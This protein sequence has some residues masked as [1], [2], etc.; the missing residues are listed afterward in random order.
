MMI[1]DDEFREVYKTS[2]TERLQKLESGLIHL[3]KNP[4]DRAKLEELLREAHT[5]KGDSRMLGVNDVET[6]THQME[7][8]LVAVKRG[9]EAFTS[10][11]CDRL[12][13]GLDAICKLVHEAVTGEE[14]GV[15]VFSVLAQLMG[16]EAENT[17]QSSEPDLFDNNNWLQ[18]TS[19]S[20]LQDPSNLLSESSWLEELANKEGINAEELFPLLDRSI[21]FETIPDIDPIPNSLAIANPESTTSDRIA[22]TEVKSPSKQPS[23]ENSSENETIR[24]DAAKLDMLMRQ[25]GELSVTKLRVER[26]LTEIEEII[27]LWEE[28]SQDSSGSRMIFRHLQQNLDSNLGEQI[29]KFQRRGETRLEKL[30]SLVKQLKSEIYDD[31]SSL[32]TIANEIESGVNNL[33]LLPFSKIFQLFPRMVRDLAKQQGKEINFTIEGG[34]TKVDKRI[35]EEMK[36][37]LLHLLRNAVD[38]GIET[39]EERDR[40]GKPPTANL[41]LRGYQS[42]NSIG[43]DIVDDG[44]GINLDSIRQTAVRRGVCTEAE[45]ANMTSNQIQSLIFAPG[46]S[47]RTE[48]TEISGRGVGL[49]VVRDNVEKLKGTI[50]IESVFGMGCEF[51]LRFSASLATTQVLI[52]EVNET[53]YAIPID[54]VETMSLISPEEVFAIEGKQTIMFAGES[55]SVLWLSDLLEFASTTSSMFRSVS[56]ESKTI[57]CIIFKLGNQRLGVFVDRLLDRQDIVLKPQSKLLKRIRHISGATILS[58]GEVCMVLHPQDFLQSVNQSSVD[59]SRR[60]AAAM[61]KQKIL[62]VEDSVIIRTQMTRLLEGAGYDVTIAVDGLEGFKTLQ[63]GKFDAIVS[64]VE[65]PNLSGLEMTAKI[66]Q[67]SEYNELPILLVTTLASPSDRQRGAEVGANAYLTKGDFDQK[68]LLDTLRRLI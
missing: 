46:F 40:S 8:C 19:N 7:E 66:R 6:L 44:R 24:V 45:L 16:A 67:L 63:G 41:R 25:A 20:Q 26:R 65:M 2:T 27:N 68:V 33:R 17:S 51:R 1:E 52:V 64:D 23:S 5:L 13:Q 12:Y 28:W 35:L 21:D 47:T 9:D 39:P 57:P 48:I 31:T 60:I 62:L 18:D 29:H 53:P 15:N 42:G 58:N 61:T 38:H 3:E 11:L 56:L 22:S 50:Y 34:D 49:D 37:P 4:D 43:I 32:E 55:V 30:G 59:I 36:D 14:A 54:D 10:A